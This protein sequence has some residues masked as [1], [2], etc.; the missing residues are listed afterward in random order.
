MPGVGPD[1][2]VMLRVANDLI[3]LADHGAGMGAARSKGILGDIIGPDGHASLPDVIC[4]A[5]KPHRLTHGVE[6]EAARAAGAD[7]K[8]ANAL[9]VRPPLM[10]G[11]AEEIPAHVHVEDPDLIVVAIV[12]SG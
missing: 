9:A 8:V 6:A 7:A 10:V 3:P 12:V 5:L 11:A 1:D 4:R 2:E